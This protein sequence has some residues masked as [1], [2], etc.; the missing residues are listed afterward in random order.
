MDAWARSRGIPLID[1]LPA[2]ADVPHPA[3]YYY[4]KDGHWSDSGQERAGRIL[5]ERL[6]A[7][8]LVPSK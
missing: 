8:G 5:A 2:F 3:A 6:I 4:R 7:L 1:L